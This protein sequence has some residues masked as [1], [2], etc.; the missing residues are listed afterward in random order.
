MSCSKILY[1]KE[2]VTIIAQLQTGRYYLDSAEIHT[3]DE[4]L[5]GSTNPY[6]YKYTFEE[7]LHY[8]V[9]ILCSPRYT[10]MKLCRKIEYR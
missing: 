8:P 10:G 6:P 3:F 7:A 1:S 2:V 9:V 5:M 4:M